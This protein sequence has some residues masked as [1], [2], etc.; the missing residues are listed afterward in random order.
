[1]YPNG[2]ANSNAFKL[3]GRPDS[4]AS[5]HL[6]RLTSEGEALARAGRQGFR[7][8]ALKAGEVR[9]LGLN[10]VHA[11]TEDDPSHTLILGN[12]SKKTCTLLAEKTRVL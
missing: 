4:E 5:V 8:G 2:T 12:N 6:A 3:G 11:P 7:L 9:A 1:M 10:V